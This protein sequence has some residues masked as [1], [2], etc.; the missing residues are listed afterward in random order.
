LGPIRGLP[1]VIAGVKV[2][3]GVAIAVMSEQCAA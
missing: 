1:I 3:N 2:A